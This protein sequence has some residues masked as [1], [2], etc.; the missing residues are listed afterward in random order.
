MSIVSIR[1][2][3]RIKAIFVSRSYKEMFRNEG[4]LIHAG[5]HVLA[6]LRDFCLA[7]AG[8]PRLFDTDPLVMA[9]R[10]GRR[11]VFDRIINFLNLDEAEVQ[12]LMEIDDGE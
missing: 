2:K 9:R 1:N 4:Q 7:K 6:D 12:T 11:E 5:Q 10:L 8:P 3:L